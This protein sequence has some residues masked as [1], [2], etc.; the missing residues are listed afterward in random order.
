MFQKRLTKTIN[1]KDCEIYAISHHKRLKVGKAE[2]DIEI[3]ENI[4]EVPT[5]GANTIQQKKTYF[6]IVVCPNPEMD[7]SIT[8]EVLRGLT[9][10]DMT[11]YLPN[12]KDVY[13]PF[14]LYGVCAA[15]L[16]PARW[17]F[18]VTDPEIVRK[19]LAL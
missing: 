18:E 7:E 13:V 11:M 5:I 12:K 15:K 6:S 17:E 4:A 3:Y 9:A 2:P 10:F 1:G 8:D 16:S 14:D 19:L